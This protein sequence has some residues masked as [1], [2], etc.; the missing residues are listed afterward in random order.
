MKRP[1]VKFRMDKIDDPFAAAKDQYPESPDNTVGELALRIGGNLFP[2]I[3]ILNSVRDCYSERAVRERINALLE[4]VNDKINAI[5]ADV[6][7]TNARLASGAYAEPIRLAMEESWRTT[8]TEKVKRFGAILGNSIAS[9]DSD[10]PR[11]A[12]EFVRTVAQLTDS[13]IQALESLCIIQNHMFGSLSGGDDP[14]TD[15]STTMFADIVRA[16]GEKK[17]ADDDFYSSCKRIEGFGLAIE[18]P[19]SHLKPA[20]YVFRPTRRGDKLFRL[21]KTNDLV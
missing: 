21:L 6:D 13:D 12:A 15:P 8:D 1:A 18:L 2:V 3:G 14:S 19:R 11:D 17:L 10:S 20:N 7:R 9:D 5:A 16:D 4:A